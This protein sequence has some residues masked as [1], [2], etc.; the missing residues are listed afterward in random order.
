MTVKQISF[1]DLDKYNEIEMLKIF[2][3]VRVYKNKK[4]YTKTN[5]TRTVID[6]AKEESMDVW[7]SIM[8]QDTCGIF[9]IEE[10][11]KWIAGAVVVTHS[12]EI[13]MLENDMTNSVLWDIRVDSEY[14]GRGYGKL[15]FDEVVKYAKQMN[16]KRLLIET[17]NNNPKAIAFYENQGANLYKLNKGHYK[18][19]PD[20]DQLIFCLE[21]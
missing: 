5:V 1:D 13:N 3:Y 18:D 15:L 6:F 16:T 14:Q 2:E 8:N 20:E 21:F 7:R 9:V 4:E 12:P 17:Q 19:Y 11:D 10:D